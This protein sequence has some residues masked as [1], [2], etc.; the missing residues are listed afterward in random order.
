MELV[1]YTEVIIRCAASSRSPL[2]TATPQVFLDRLLASSI[3]KTNGISIRYKLHHST[4]SVTESLS[5]NTG[6]VHVQVHNDSFRIFVPSDKKSQE[7]CYRRHFPQALANLFRIDSAS[8]E[9]LSNV[10]NSTLTIMDDLLEEAG[11]AQVPGIELPARRTVDE[12]D[13]PD[14]VITEDTMAQDEAPQIRFASASIKVENEFSESDSMPPAPIY[15]PPRS[16]ESARRESRSPRPQGISTEEV[17]DSS[18]AYRELLS[19]VIRV[20][21]RTELPRCNVLAHPSSGQNFPGFNRADAFGVRSQ[22]QI[23]HDVKIGAAGEL[24]VSPLSHILIIRR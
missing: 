5:K 22:N 1:L 11:I 8:R 2:A 6:Y 7:I 20:A 12:P 18:S 23:N 10:L 21:N 14:E 13:E 24:F 19:H 4:G 3:M 16:P 15:T 9:I 17:Y